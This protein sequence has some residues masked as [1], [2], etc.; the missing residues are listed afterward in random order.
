MYKK[1][2]WVYVKPYIPKEVRAT[3]IDY[4]SD[5]TLKHLNQ[6][7]RFRILEIPDTRYIRVH[8][9]GEGSL[10]GFIPLRP[11]EVVLC[12]EHIIEGQAEWE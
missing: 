1:G 6:Y 7:G 10:S 11:E 8:V 9:P 4:L 2:D 12:S 3:G 5:A